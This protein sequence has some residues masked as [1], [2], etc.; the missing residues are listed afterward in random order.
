MAFLPTLLNYDKSNKS[1]NHPI[2]FVYYLLFMKQNFV[3]KP[4]V[5]RQAGTPGFFK[6]ILCRSSVCVYVSAPEAINNLW[7]DMDSI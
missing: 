1:Q 5:R 2:T 6:L 7:R 4:G 3:F